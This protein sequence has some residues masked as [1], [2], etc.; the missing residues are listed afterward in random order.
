[1]HARAS[2]CVVLHVPNID[3]APF[4]SSSRSARWPATGTSYFLV[5]SR[6]YLVA[7]S[8]ARDSQ[9]LSP[10][11][12]ELAKSYQRWRAGAVK[13]AI[14]RVTT[15]WGRGR[16]V[17]VAVAVTAAVVTAGTASRGR[18]RGRAVAVAAGRGH[19]ACPVPPC[20]RS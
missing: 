18:G 1:M 4:V 15:G 5:G 19:G 2:G 7:G 11:C 10:S 9:E 8:L 20:R 14:T 3:M 17:A 16:A 13:T 12:R 6:S